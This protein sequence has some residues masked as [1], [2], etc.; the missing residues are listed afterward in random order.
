MN[1]Y[2]ITFGG[3]DDPMSESDRWFIFGGIHRD[4]VK[5]GKRLVES[6]ENVG[7]KGHFYDFNWLKSTDEYHNN[8]ITFSKRPYAW[9]FKPTA[10]WHK[11][12]EINDGDVVI[13]CDTNH[14]VNFYPNRI[15]DVAKEHGIFT[16][17]HSPTYYPNM[18]WTYR[19]TFVEMGCD[20]ERYWKAPQ[21]RANVIG[22]C[23][24]NFTMNFVNE[25]KNYTCN[26]NVTM[27]NNLK[28]FPCFT[29]TRDDQSV[30]SI[31]VEKYKIPA[32]ITPELNGM[33]VE[34]KEMG[35]DV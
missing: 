4:Y 5:E 8:P 13:W 23:K 21:M 27:T 6:A 7:L 29:D 20:E 22:I 16:Y 11:L 25:W 19:D 32:Q 1:T 24:N 30:F 2:L 15:I 17:D 14:F 9:A 3:S 28:N 18:C 34:L 31:L 26:K 12:N 33:I 10:I 35:L